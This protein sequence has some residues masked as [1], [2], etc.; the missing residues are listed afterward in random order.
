MTTQAPGAQPGVGLR[1][2]VAAD[3]TTRP[4][5]TT[6]I[7]VLVDRYLDPGTVDRQAL[8][9]RSSTAVLTEDDKC[10]DGVVLRPT[11][12]PIQRVAT[13][14]LDPTPLAA[15]T[16]YRL[17]LR[18]AGDEGL[19]SFDGVPL[20]GIFALEFTTAEAVPDAV[21]EAPPVGPLWCG[22]PEC[23]AACAGNADC[24]AKCSI[25]TILLASCAVGG[26]HAV[27]DGEGPAAMGL[28]LSSGAAVQA[29]AI[30]HV[31]RGTQR[32]PGAAEAD[33][34]SIAFGRAM[35]I[36]QP[37][38]PGR[39]YLLYKIAAST[40]EGELPA[41]DGEKD[42]LREGLVVG[43]PMPAPPYTPPQAA[44]LDHLVRWIA[45]GADVSECP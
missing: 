37:S 22:T 4:L 14:Y 34:S 6:A 8:C 29:T 20:E 13:F 18:R 27:V 12:D 25:G 30:G 2:P 16:F 17:T 1:V 38:D 41:A 35:P 9:L 40:L 5:P 26:C 31:A 39:S 43:M 42:R 24:Q 33:V 32:G 44:K 45:A 3:G 36:I 7:R 28:D 19:R 10:T 23:L 15:S 21:V 11:Y